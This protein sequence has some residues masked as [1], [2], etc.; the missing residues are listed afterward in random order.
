MCRKYIITNCDLIPVNRV[1]VCSHNEYFIGSS[2]IVV[3]VTV[4]VMA[5]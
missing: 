5:K 2:C 1:T 4:I 3:T